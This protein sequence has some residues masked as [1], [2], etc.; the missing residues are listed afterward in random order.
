MAFG[1]NYENSKAGSSNG[2][3]RESPYLR[4]KS[5]ERV[6]RILDDDAVS[7]WQYF[8][9]VNVGGKVTG[10]SIIVGGARNP[11]KAFMDTLEEGHPKY[12]RPSRRYLI[13]VY[14]RTPVIRAEGQTYYAD[15]RGNFPPQANVKDKDGF[16]LIAEPNNRIMLL[17]YGP[18][19][20]ED[21]M[22]L[23]KRIR[24]PET[25]VPMN[26]QEFDIRIMAKGVGRDMKKTPIPGTDRD[27]TKPLPDAI[28]NGPR[29][30]LQLATRPLPDEAQERLLAGEDYSTVIRS[31]GWESIKPLW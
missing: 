20:M 10:R 9:D 24:N 8:L 2:E 19:M 18:S 1:Q 25:A 7:F 22:T 11:I 13:N 14:D 3:Q 31:L 26:I 16:P 27:S 12:R 4:I 30:D 29:Y 6:I 28:A 5:G 21:F 15:D 17:E 23:H